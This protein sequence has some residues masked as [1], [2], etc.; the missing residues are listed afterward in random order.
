MMRQLQKIN[1][2]YTGFPLLQPKAWLSA[3]KHAA[4]HAECDSYKA[5][6]PHVPPQAWFRTTLSSSLN[7]KVLCDHRSHGLSILFSGNEKQVK[8]SSHS[9]D[10]ETGPLSVQ[11]GQEHRS[12][13]LLSRPCWKAPRPQQ[14]QR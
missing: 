1:P 3:C 13:G 9:F 4:H 8:R 14:Q 10:I 12:A 7:C 2:Y 6:P 11:G 5:L